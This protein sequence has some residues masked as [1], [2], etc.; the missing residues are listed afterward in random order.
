MSII[1]KQGDRSEEVVLLQKALN[2][3]AGFNLSK[4]G[5]F[6]PGTR[7]SLRSFQQRANYNVD[8][9]Y[10]SN[11]H[12]E[13]ADLIERK[14][15]R[16]NDIAQYADAI[17]VEPAFL[18]AVTVVESRGSGFFDNGMCAILYERH[19]FY[20]K[21][22]AKFGKKKADQWASKYPNLCYPTRSQAA[23]YGGEREYERLNQAKNLD[24]ECALLS[25]SYGMFQIMGFN[26]A[27]CGY[28]TVGDYVADMIESERYHVGAVSLLIKNQPSWL[29]PA[30]NLDFNEFARKYNGSSYAEHNYHGRLRQ[31]YKVFLNT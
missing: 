14:Y 4:D 12:I 20:N 19:I 5:D 9:I 15:I 3:L 27:V 6:G 26:Y 29:A 22:A 10:D 25:A 13:L 8:G 17:G 21:V 28:E 30:R 23:Y 24:S 2:E 11:V 16:L 7:N 1:L 31:A 18:K